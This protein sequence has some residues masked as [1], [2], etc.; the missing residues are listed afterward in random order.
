MEQTS[1]HILPLRIDDIIALK[2][3]G[4][5]ITC[6]SSFEIN[7]VDFTHMENEF[8]AIL[9]FCRWSGVM[10]GEEYSFRKCYARGCPHNLCPQV[11]QAVMIA[12]RYLQQDYRRLKEAG[13]NVDAKLF[14][15]DD[16]VVRFQ[17]FRE[18]QAPTL[19][20]EDY[21]HIAKEGSD[22]SMKVSVE[23]LPAV[24][25]FG[26]RKEQRTFFLATFD[27]TSLGLDHRIQR[28]LACY[29]ADQKADEKL[30]QVRIANDRLTKIFKEFDLAGI[31]YGKRFF[32]HQEPRDLTA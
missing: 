32:D 20:L 17:I 1:P 24:E 27:V 28:C 4:A 8:R 18:E 9:F 14:S 16:M 22:V 13:I 15:L 21:L 7:E 2:K 3:N 10:D 30:R 19:S 31:K 26:N 11:S 6:Q 29:G 5:S 12:N 25:N 23:Y